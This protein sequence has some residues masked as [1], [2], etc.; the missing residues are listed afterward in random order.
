MPP[1]FKEDE[2]VLAFHGPL[3]HEAKVRECVTRDAPD[4]KTKVNLYLVHYDGFTKHWDEWV[5][6]SR[7]LKSN[8][9]NKQKQKQRIKEFHRAHKRVRE[10]KL[11]GPAPS[12]AAGG[13]A[14]GGNG[15]AKAQKTGSAGSTEGV[16]ENLEAT[17]REQ[18]RLPHAAKLKLIEDWE[19]ITREKKL[20]P[21]GE[22]ASIATLIDDFLSAKARRTTSHERLYGE[23]AE[24]VK[25]YFEQALP[26]I[27]LYKFERRQWRE[28][29][30]SKKGEPAVNY[31][32]AEHLL[33]LYVKLPELL[34]RCTMQREHMTVLVAKL[35]ELLRFL[36]TQ[37]SKYF[38]AE[39]V[40]PDAEYL[41]WWT[42]GSAE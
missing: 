23:V 30:E 38:A 17:L 28:L 25:A 20:A 34:A 41:R 1:A 8:D 27:L 31:Y 32:G 42:G 12:S 26:T 40:A 7:M 16:E 19:H 4:G 11:K 35:G 22:G 13:S 6:E 14:A 15:K 36:M 3:I 39:Y 5:P 10:D 21:V 29:K 2:I 33:R 24:G 9:E 37:K 18:L